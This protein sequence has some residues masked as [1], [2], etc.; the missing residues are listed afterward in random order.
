MCNATHFHCEIVTTSTTALIPASGFGIS[1]F[2]REVFL[3]LRNHTFNLGNIFTELLGA[4]HGGSKPGL[5]GL[6]GLGT[7]AG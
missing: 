5:F 1:Q 4:I 2:T 6:L 3:N 7:G